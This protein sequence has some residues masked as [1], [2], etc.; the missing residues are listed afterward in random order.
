MN[1]SLEDMNNTE[2]KKK[3]TLNSIWF[4]LGGY[5]ENFLA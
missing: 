5:L 4:I 1:Q 3:K 2:H